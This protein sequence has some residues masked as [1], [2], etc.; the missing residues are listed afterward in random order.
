M[1][2]KPIAWLSIIIATL[3]PVQLFS[4]I[5]QSAPHLSGSMQVDAQYY[6]ADTLIGTENVPERILM[7]AFTRLNYQQGP[8]NAALRFESYLNPLLGFDNRYEGSGLAFRSISYRSD[9]IDI[10][11]GNFYEQ[12]GNG[13]ILRSYEDW[14]LGLDNSLDGLKVHLRPTSGVVIKGI[15]GRHRYFWDVSPGIIRGAD[16]E[17][18]LNDVF[19]NLAEQTTRVTVGAGIVS[20]YQKDEFILHSPGLRFVLPLNVAAASGRINISG[21]NYFVTAEYAR[22]INDPSVVNGFIYK[23]GQAMYVSASYFR[24]GFSLLMAAKHTD[25]MSF[26]SRRTETGNVLDIN[27]LPPLTRQ[28]TYSLA[29]MYPYATQPNG[30]IAVQG[31]LIYTLRRGSNFGGK[32]GTTLSV[33]YSRVHDLNRRA[34]ADT[35]PIGARGTEGYRAAIF[36][37]GDRKFFDE[38]SVLL[39]RRLTRNLKISLQYLNLFYNIEV[40]QGRAGSEDVLA[41]IWVADLQYRFTPTL[42]LRTELQHL[43]TQQDKGDWLSALAEFTLAPRWFFSVGNE[44]NYGNP[45][46][47]ARIHYY[48]VSAGYTHHT[49]RIA[50]SYGRQRAGVICVGGICRFV[51]A[52]NGLRLTVTSSF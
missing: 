19:G 27:F 23:Y 18:H 52:S 48:N 29:A 40:I 24:H 38:I 44:F 16:A 6:L 45:D 14:N 49:T 39:S 31:Q 36:D 30:E 37:F 41:S 7:N 46:E 12:F 2:A 17:L 50:F 51:P 47:E 32:Y 34:I 5:F 43:A 20:R 13:M 35:I 10:T 15:Y 21:R 1:I 42:A 25:N 3:I 9:L 26:K 33:N 28:H 4:Q 11:A 22:K 8:F